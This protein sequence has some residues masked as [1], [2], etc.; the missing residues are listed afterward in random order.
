MTKW[1]DFLV[2]QWLRPQAPNLGALVQSL[3]RELDPL[4]PRGKS[5]HASREKKDPACCNKDG[6]PLVPKL[7]PS[8]AK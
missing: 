1:Q 2:V 8:V 5:S 4:C 3:V 6:R 7:R